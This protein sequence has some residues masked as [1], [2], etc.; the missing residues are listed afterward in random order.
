LRGALRANPVRADHGPTTVISC[1]TWGVQ[2]FNMSP[3][4]RDR[5]QSQCDVGKRRV[6]VDPVEGSKKSHNPRRP[7]LPRRGQKPAP[8]G[9]AS[10]VPYAA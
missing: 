10:A 2:L 1:S 5:E 6:V 4:R 8:G 9:A 3:H 7:P